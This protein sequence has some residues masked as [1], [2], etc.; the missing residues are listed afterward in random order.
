MYCNLFDC[1]T[2]SDNSHDGHSSISMLCE[3]ACNK[4][5]SGIC[6]TDHCECDVPVLNYIP[7][8]QGVQFDMMKA[9]SAFSQ[10]LTLLT[11]I[12]LGQPHYDPQ[13]AE[14]M[15]SAF[16][17]DFVLASLHNNPGEEDLCTMDFTEMPMEQI[18]DMLQ[19]YYENMLGLAQWN[20]F[21]SLGHITYPLRYIQGFQG[22][23]VDMSPYDALIREILKTVADNGKAIEINTSTIRQGLGVTMPGIEYVK[24]FKELGGK[25]VTIGSDAHYAK[26]VGADL[27]VALDMLKEA[28]FDC[29][30]VYRRREPKLLKI[31]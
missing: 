24:L 3:A 18:N 7:R 26:D 12:E 28:G 8:F 9:R 16:Q 29:F 15:L 21:D 25:Y 13:L 1:H 14:Q 11:G 22:I 27:N 31:L 2:H 30:T 5:L 4:G 6:I 20:Q 17:F 23:P 19:R 10:Q